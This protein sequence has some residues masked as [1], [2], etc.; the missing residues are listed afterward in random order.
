MSVTILGTDFMEIT[1]DPV[2]SNATEIIAKAHIARIIPSK[3]I[4]RQP[5]DDEWDY[6]F[7]SITVITFHIVDGRKIELELQ[8]VSNQ[9]GWNDGS[10]SSMSNA[11]NDINI[12]L[13]GGSL[14]PSPNILVSPSSRNFSNTTIVNQ[15]SASQTITVSGNNLTNDIVLTAPAGWIINLDNSTNDDGPIT[16][17]QVAG[18]VSPTNVYIRLAPL[19]VQSYNGTLVITSTGALTQNVSLIGSAA[20]PDVDSVPTS[21]IFDDTEVDFLS[22]TESI[23]VGGVNLFA[24]LVITAPVGW[25]INLDG[26]DNDSGPISLVPDGSGDVAPTIIYIKFRPLT[27]GTYSDDLTVSSTGATTID[28]ALLGLALFPQNRVYSYY[29]NI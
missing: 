17:V 8:T 25:I 16:L 28:V 3:Y 14:A 27:P 21:L 12:W 26:S 7:N 2:A 13:N 18:T 5:G 19:A 24:N 6:P 10:Q 1:P 9:S 11:Q 4:E 20:T 23:T 22:A 29:H 15:I